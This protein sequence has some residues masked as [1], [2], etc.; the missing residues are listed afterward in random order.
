M[1]NRN[2]RD[3]REEQNEKLIEFQDLQKNTI[4]S[5]KDKVASLKYEL[6]EF[7]DKNDD[8]DNNAEILSKLFDQKIINDKGNVLDKE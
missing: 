8:A 5:L 3:A 4:R 2:K 7:H 1:L 6:A